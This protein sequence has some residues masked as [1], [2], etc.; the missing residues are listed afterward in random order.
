MSHCLCCRQ[1]GGPHVRYLWANILLPC[2]LSLPILGH[3]HVT[4]RDHSCRSP[5]QYLRSAFDWSYPISIDLHPLIFGWNSK[6][7]KIP[8]LPHFLDQFI[9]FMELHR[10]MWRGIELFDDWLLR[11]AGSPKP[12]EMWLFFGRSNYG[13]RHWGA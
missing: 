1:N 2:F 11:H 13:F 8:Y 6:K 5:Y 12:G 4:F 10:E 7:G 3:A 9:G